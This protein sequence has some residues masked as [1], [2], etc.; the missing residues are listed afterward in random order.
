[1]NLRAAL[2]ILVLG[3]CLGAQMVQMK[4]KGGGTLK[5]GDISYR[6]EVTDLQTAPAKGGLPGVVRMHGNLLPP[7]GAHPFHMILTVMKDGSLYMLQ[8][9]RKAHGAYPD[10]WA[11][12]Q[13][14]R[15]R[16]LRLVDRPGGKV[17]IR[18]EGRLT[19]IIAKHPQE[20]D[21]S[22]TLWAIFPGEE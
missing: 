17:E 6:L 10:T 11:A 7:G 3:G 5:I 21:W 2:P 20:A 8:I 13:K 15:T 18:C 16:A 1:M 12:T 14:T 4:P 22:G 9:E 19:G